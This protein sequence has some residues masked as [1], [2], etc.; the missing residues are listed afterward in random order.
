MARVAVTSRDLQ[1]LIKCNLEIQ[2]WIMK[3]NSY[4]QPKIIW[5][6]D[7]VGVIMFWKHHRSGQ[8]FW[9]IY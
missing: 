2:S 3:N 7:L 5:Y 8:R 4:S 6:Y 9:V 1:F